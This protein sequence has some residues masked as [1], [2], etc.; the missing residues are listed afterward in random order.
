MKLMPVLFAVLA[1]MAWGAYVPT[2]HHGQKG[3]DSQGSAALRAFLCVGIA[4]FLVAVIIP[5][6][7]FANKVEPLQFTS[8][9]VSLSVLAGILGAVGALCVIFALKSGGSPLYVAPI[10]FA[11]APVIN[12]FVSM[13]WSRPSKPPGSLFYAGVVLVAAGVALVLR[14]KPV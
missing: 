9:G 13:I 6:I 1:A 3:F 5:G 10:V 4:Y 2:I 14:F 7:L 12:V 11:L 8:K